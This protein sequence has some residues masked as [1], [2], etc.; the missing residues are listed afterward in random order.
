[1]LT[2][3]PVLNHADDGQESA[4]VMPEFVSPRYGFAH[5]FD[6][7]VF[8]LMA[9]GID[10]ERITVSRM[11]PG[12]GSLRIVAQDPPAGK[13]LGASEQIVLSV[14]GDG[15]FDRLPTAL[16]GDR[17]TELEPGVDSLMLPFDDASEKASCYVRQGGLYFDLRPNNPTGCARWIRLFGIA[18]ENW[19]EDSWYPLAQLLPS[20]HRFSG[21]EAAIRLGVKLMLGLDIAQLLWGRQNTLLVEQVRTR[22]GDLSTRLGVDFIV[23]RAVEDESVL[24]IILGPMSFAEYRRHRDEKMRRLLEQVLD[25]VLPCHIVHAVDWLVGDPDYSPRLNTNEDNTVLGI[26]MHLGKRVGLMDRRAVSVK[27]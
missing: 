18:P 1:V 21:Q 8:S 26:N 20:L 15:L 19:P 3:M 5:T 23:G 14:A 16:R 17:G 11:G 25:L 4:I 7:A 12:W 2:F 9:L 22:I 24:K 10:P 13:R 6:S 27:A